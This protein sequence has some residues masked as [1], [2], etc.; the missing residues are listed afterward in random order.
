MN[1]DKKLRLMALKEYGFSKAIKDD[2]ISNDDLKLITESTTNGYI[3]H[4]IT[5][6]CNRRTHERIVMSLNNYKKAR[7]VNGFAAARA[8]SQYKGELHDFL[9]SINYVNDVDKK[10]I[11][12]ELAK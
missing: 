4:E 1:L 6:I 3:Q 5:C 8:R 2:T 12:R 7:H 11:E 9:N 10:M